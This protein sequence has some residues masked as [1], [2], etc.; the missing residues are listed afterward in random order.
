MHQRPAH[1]DQKENE[2]NSQHRITAPATVLLH[3]VELALDRSISI[4][5]NLRAI[6]S[7]VRR[8]LEGDVNLALHGVVRRKPGAIANRAETETVRRCRVIEI[9]FARYLGRSA[10]EGIGMI[11]SL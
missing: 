3:P 5:I 7:G 2:H 8:T 11:H 10:A 6:I 4:R 1:L 9:E